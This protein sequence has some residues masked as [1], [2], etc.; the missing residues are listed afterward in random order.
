MSKAHN[1]E[2][3]ARVQQ[4]LREHGMSQAKL[5]QVT[6]INK[7]I[8][9]Q[10][11]RG[12][13]TGD[14]A[15]VEQALEEYLRTAVEHEQA[16][17]TALP[18]VATQDYIPTSI[19]EDVYKMIKYCQ[20]E[21]GIM[22]AHGDAGIGKTKAAQKFV[23]DNPTQS[24]Y[25]QA[26][27]STGTLG[28]ILKLLARALRI[29]E[30][31]SKLDLL[32][33]IRAKLDGSNKVIIIDEAQHLKLSALEEIRTLAD[34]NT[35]TGQE[36]IG[37][38]LI[39]NTEVYGRMMGRQEARFAQLF[40]RV[41]FNRYYNTQRIKRADVE[42]LFPPLRRREKRERLTCWRAS[43]GAN[44]V[45]AVRLMYTIT[46]LTATISAMTAC[47][48]GL[49]TSA[50]AWWY[51]EG[52]YGKMDTI[53]AGFCGRIARGDASGQHRQ[54]HRVLARRDAGR[55]DRRPADDPLVAVCGMHHR[56][57]AQAAQDLSERL[58]QGVSGRRG[59]RRQCPAS[60]QLPPPDTTC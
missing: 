42:M 20:L 40:S 44:L 19:S 36:G 10:W 38:V 51:E 7:A 32:T 1:A 15:G 23:R 60:R 55:R 2:L 53:R 16:R 45:C 13:Y 11:L 46:R 58:S 22:I 47:M 25:I 52:Q 54:Y 26:T 33:N 29:P 57:G 6:G 43:A 18:M 17:E 50:S 21:R 27:P 8:I 35:I 3:Q 48:R 56:A 39:G 4:Y 31:R 24:I 37:I 30:T 14:I 5:A 59:R 49:A 12:Q 41:K 34:P 28:N 9:S